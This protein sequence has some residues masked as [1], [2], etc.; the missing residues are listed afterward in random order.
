MREFLFKPARKLNLNTCVYGV[1]YPDHSR[2]MPFQTGIEYGGWPPNYRAPQIF[3]NFKFTAHVPRR[4]HVASLP[5]VPTI[6]VFEAAGAGAY[7][8]PAGSA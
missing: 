1:R 3:A 6:R 8:I 4:T 7:L 2:E 5:G